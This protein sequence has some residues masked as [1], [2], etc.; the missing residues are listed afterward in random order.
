ME[1]FIVNNEI[2]NYIGN[3]ISDDTGYWSFEY[4]RE[5]E[6]IDLSHYGS[7]F[8]EAIKNMFAD[9]TITQVI[10]IISNSNLPDLSKIKIIQYLLDLNQGIGNIILERLDT[11]EENMMSDIIIKRL[12]KLEKLIECQN[13]RINILVDAL[14]LVIKK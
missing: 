14:D 5:Y 2:I 11:F 12:D 7:S 4:F 3:C 10:Y 13:D 1:D 6:R 9:K 8:N